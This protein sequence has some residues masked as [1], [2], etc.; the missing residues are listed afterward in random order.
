VVPPILLRFLRRDG[1]T[2]FINAQESCVR[3]GMHVDK[4]KVPHTSTP[5]A[6]GNPWVLCMGPLDIVF[7]FTATQSIKTK[8]SAYVEIPTKQKPQS[9][10][11]R[12]SL[13]T[14]TACCI[15]LPNKPTT[16]HFIKNCI[17]YKVLYV[18]YMIVPRHRKRSI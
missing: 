11:I 5:S 2:V 7:E 18:Q 14:Q 13:R 15:K 1:K 12:N 16:Q 6:L 17:V 3:H 8:T 4:L 10:A 9:R